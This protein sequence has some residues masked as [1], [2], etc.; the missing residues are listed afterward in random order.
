MRRARSSPEVLC[1]GHAAYDL[2]L[3]T[4][5][6]PGENTKRETDT[7]LETGGG[8][9]ANAAY[10]LSLWGIKSAFAGLLGDDHFGR[11]ILAEFAAGGT[12]VSLVEVR[13]GHKTPLSI[14]LV[15]ELNGSRTLINRKAKSGFLRLN[16]A[17]LAR[18]S[19]GVLLFD[20]HELEA[21]LIAL[22][23]FAK[24]VSILDAGSLR[25]GTSVL[26]HKVNYLVA[27]EKFGRQACGLK[28]LSSRRERSA[29]VRKLRERCGN[30]VVITL[31][32]HGLIGDSGD[33]YFEMPAFPTKAID[34]TGAGDIFHGA[35]AY[36]IAQDMKLDSALRLASMAAS[37]SVRRKGGRGSI[38]TLAE[39]KEAL[40]NA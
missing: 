9:A 28:A 8:P 13:P 35:F 22:G 4:R 27:S 26:A 29:A 19:P 11:R 21:S 34:T 1:I 7:M 15:N 16:P 31:G 37:L 20:G 24:A 12:D 17:A 6:F 18:L 33:G 2:S 36:A 38:P 23:R 40:R 39:V 3:F 25:E 5:G 14:I 30:T 32:E 10:L